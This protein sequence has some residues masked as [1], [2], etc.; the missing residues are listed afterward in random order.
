MSRGEIVI[1][2]CAL[3]KLNQQGH[4]D[5]HTYHNIIGAGTIYDT[6]SNKVIDISHYRELR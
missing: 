1:P 5:N 4:I 2:V 6:N 3:V